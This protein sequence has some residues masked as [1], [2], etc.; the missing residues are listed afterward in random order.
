M[1]RGLLR[2]VATVGG[3]TTISRLLGFARDLVL[4]RLFGASEAADAFFVALRIPNLF[5]RLF[6]EGAFSQAFVPVLGE[7]RSTRSAEET[8]AFL[9]DVTGWLMLALAGVTVI[10]TLAAGFI[11]YAIAPGFAADPGKFALTTELLRIT[12]PY[13]FFISLVALAGGILNTHGKFSVPA[14]TPA[15]LNISMIACALWLAPGMAQPAE[16]VAWGVFLGG[17]LQLLFQIPFLLALRQLPL[18]R[19]RVRDPGVAK[20]LRLMGPAAFGASV[21][22][23]NLFLN[24]VLASLVG[25]NVVSYLY[26][27]DRLVEFPLG[28]FGVAL[29]TVVL[30]ALSR[31]RAEGAEDRYNA[32]LDWALRLTLL[33]GLPATVG[34]LVLGE[35]MLT[36]LFRYGAFTAQDVQ[37]SYKSLVGYGLGILP[38]VAVRALAPAFY[39]RQD[40][41]TPVKIGMV[42]L[43]VNMVFSLILAWPLKQGGLALATTLASIANAL[44]LWRALHRR[45]FYQPLPGWGLLATKAILLS[46]GMG[47]VLYFFKGPSSLW[48]SWS[49]GERLLHLVALVLLG[50]AIYGLGAW[51]LGIG[52]IRQLRRRV[53]H[54]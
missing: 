11:V 44:L 42:A 46:G 19:L 40:T 5:R 6:G 28:V 36:S 2:A 4:A 15:L 54:A 47:L 9:D 50:L 31:A 53:P 14:I 45:G 30:P 52:E 25:A 27:S 17:V 34:L 23:L 22:Q 29:G 48:L 37:E 33:I 38:I 51:L 32:M 21:A 39:A 1:S 20:V 7:Y 18:P 13:L 49:L 10:G 24:T 43:V 3:N 12:F 35:P 16:A 8:R 41:R 26:Y